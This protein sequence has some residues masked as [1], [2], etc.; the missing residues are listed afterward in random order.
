MGGQPLYGGP[1]AGFGLDPLRS[2]R[3]FLAGVAVGVIVMSAAGL[4]AARLIESPDQLAARTAP[5]AVSVITGVAGLRTL[6]NGI[7]VPGTVRPGRT[8]AVTAAAPYTAVIVTRMPV[9]LGHRVWPGHV[10]AQIDGR[11]VL[12][13]RGKLPPYRDLRQGDTGLDVAQLQTALT[14]LGYADYDPAGDFGPST[15]L[16]VRLLYQHL[17]Y[18]P[19]LYRPKAPGHRRPGTHPPPPRVYLPMSEVAYIPAAS[20][21]VVAVKAKAGTTVSAGQVVLRLATGHPYVTG[22]LS[23]HQAALARIGSAARISLASPRLADAGT[24]TGLGAIPAYASHGRGRI[25]YPVDV[26]VNRPLPEGLIGTT[27]R[28]TIWSAITSTPVL[29]VPLAAVFRGPPGKLGKPGKAGRV[30]ALATYVTTVPADGRPR[31]VPVLTGPAD[32]G[33]VAV[34]PASPAALQPGDHVVIGVSR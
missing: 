14:G 22:M 13:L 7:V 34:Q 19:P 15:A 8:V 5:P 33:F 25:E 21:L 26:T 23:A 30:P 3:F 31:R 24:V 10:I 28:L 4:A 9:K 6:R 18:S 32:G 27:V 12:L 29:T 1:K 11:P 17:G 20:A 2:R 16:A